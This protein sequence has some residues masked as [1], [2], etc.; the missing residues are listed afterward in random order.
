MTISSRHALMFNDL[1]PNRSP[2]NQST[3]SRV[4]KEF[5]VTGTVKDSPKS[6]RPKTATRGDKALDILPSAREN[7]I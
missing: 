7:P 6:G 3:V 2:I 5:Q 1:Y 4:A